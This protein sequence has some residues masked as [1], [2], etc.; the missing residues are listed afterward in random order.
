MKTGSR[1]EMPAAWYDS[2]VG[3]AIKAARI[4]VAA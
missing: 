3:A 2:E 1:V 4:A